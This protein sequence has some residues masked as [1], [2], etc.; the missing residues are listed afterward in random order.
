MI[1]SLHPAVLLLSEA[2][3]PGSE[4]IYHLFDYFLIAAFF[5]AA[6][7]TFLV[8]YLSFRYRAKKDDPEPK[9]N[10]GNHKIEIT[11]TLITACVVGFFFYLT[12]STMLSIQKPAGNHK[13]DVVITGH[14]WWWEV[15]YPKDGVIAANEIHLPVGKKLLINLKTADVI[16]DWWVP[17]LGRKMDMIPGRTNHIWLTINKP[18]KYEGACSEYCG[19]QHAWMRIQV[20]AQSPNQFKKWEE[21]HAQPAGE[22]KS[23]LAQK[24]KNLFMRSTCV[25][26]HAIE[27]TKAGGRI[28]PDLT[29]IGSRKTLLTGMMKNDPENLDKWLTN[30]QKVKKGAHMPNFLFKKQQV[31]ELSAYLEGLK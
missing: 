8:F 6:S 3:S 31:R 5:V 30:P 2:A 7:I 21:H 24:G 19:A 28:G 26:C 14:Q 12:V 10:H 20:I 15:E 17:A 29:H 25:N 4:S 9:Q 27:G 13:P 1:H 23:N 16:H 11:L 18:G 22:P